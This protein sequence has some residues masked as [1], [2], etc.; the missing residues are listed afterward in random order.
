MQQVGREVCHPRPR[1][2]LLLWPQVL[3][4]Q[5]LQLLHQA[6]AVPQQQVPSVAAAAAALAPAPGVQQAAKELLILALWVSPVPQTQQAANRSS[7]NQTGPHLKAQQVRPAT[8]LCPR[9]VCWQAFL[10]LLVQSLQCGGAP[11]ARLVLLDRQSQWLVCW[12]GPGGLPMPWQ[13]CWHLHLC[14]WWQTSPSRRLP[15]AL[16]QRQ[17]AQLLQQTQGQWL[18]PSGLLPVLLVLPPQLQLRHQPV[19]GHCTGRQT[20]CSSSVG[21]SF[22]T[23]WR[24]LGSQAAQL[25]GALLGCCRQ[26]RRQQCCCSSCCCWCHSCC[27]L[28][29]AT[30]AQHPQV[31]PAQ[32]LGRCSLLLA[33]NAA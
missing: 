19:Q 8:H 1:Q 5:Q 27:L 31:L 17:A 12:E 30:L 25:P 24:Q 14:G 26:Q 3:G 33:G 13:V 16:V 7:W 9:P 18:L 23:S 32:G 6:E 11:Q 28:A 2:E 22:G 15:A 21:S 10:Q 4:L 20:A 29:G